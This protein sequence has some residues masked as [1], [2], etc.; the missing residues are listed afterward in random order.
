MTKI[1]QIQNS[2]GSAG[3]AALRLQKAFI[4]VNIQSDIVSLQV[5]SPAIEHVKYLNKIGRLIAHIDNK[6]QS[7]ITK[8]IPKQ[9]GLFSYP[10]L[11]N[12]ISHIAEIKNADIIYIHWIQ[13]GL[14]SLKNIKQIAALNKP[15]IIFMHD[16]WSITGGCHYSFDCKNYITGCANCQ[17]FSNAKISGFPSREFKKKLKLYSAYENL[18]FVSPS[19]WL[20]NCAKESLLTIKKPVYYI[21]NVLDNTV[22]KPFDKKIARQ[23]LN[24]GVNEK[25]IAFGAV[26]IGSPYKG[27]SY[28]QKAMEILIQQNDIENISVLVFGS[29]YN[30]QT[31]D[32]IPFKTKFMGYLYDEYSTSLVYNAADVVVTPSLADNQPTLVQESLCCGTPV[33]GFDVGGIP[34]MIRH[35]ENGYLAKYKDAADLAEGIKFCLTSIVKASMLP[36]FMPAITINKHLELWEKI[37]NK[38]TS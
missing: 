19:K 20:Y 7:I 37:K 17:M 27:W 8:R 32:A 33:V 11:G 22:F 6:L 34:D 31:A 5:D 28:L 13:Y 23:M 25:V 9:F 29:G 1:V 15:T 16:M 18:Y 2:S 36:E 24:I 4:N 30:K 10:L 14:L 35:R 21:P 3:S 38:T 12:N 26:S